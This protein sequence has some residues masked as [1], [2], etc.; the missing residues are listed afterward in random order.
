MTR[1]GLFKALLVALFAAALGAFVA[2]DGPHHLSVAALTTDR[3]VLVR[4]ADAHRAAAMAIA[5]GAYAGAVA[6]SLPGGL[7]FSLACGLMF[8]R[9]LGTAVAVA[10]GTVGATLI[11]LATRYVVAGF[12]RSHLP[13]IGERIIAGFARHAFA[14][15]LVLRVV[16]LFPFF[17]VNLAPAFTSMR[18]PTYIAATLLGIIPAT[19]VY[20]NLGQAL[21]QADSLRA[22][23]SVGTL[24]PFAL[25]V[26][27][28]I[29][30][31]LA[32]RH[33]LRTR[34]H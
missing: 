4:F 28:A 17:L 29:L 8:G 7:V 10:A 24:G 32:R 16:P 33:L 25:L 13:A 18:L 30:S 26:A 31:V 20:A 9:I 15:L 27:L 23:L 14:Y 12:V 2:L 1:S 3:D 19:F 34:V 6:L 21:G 5:F 22:A 11:F